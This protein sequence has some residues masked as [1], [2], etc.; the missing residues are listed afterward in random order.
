[1]KKNLLSIIII[2]VLI[3]FLVSA[4]P[5]RTDIKGCHTEKS[6][7]SYHCHKEPELV[8]E[9]RVHARVFAPTVKTK[10]KDYNCADFNTHSEAQSWFESNGGTNFDKYRLDADLDGVACENL[11]H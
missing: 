9:A 7:G 8:K 6:T 4:S 11:L 3:P 1:M 5:G 10:S 2:S